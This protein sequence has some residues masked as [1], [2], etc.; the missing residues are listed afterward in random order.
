MVYSAVFFLLALSG[1]LGVLVQT[2]SEHRWAILS[3]L[4]GA[5]PDLPSARISAAA[6]QD[7]VQL[8]AP[9]CVAA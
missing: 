8:L 6:R 2:I 3:A 5:T 7:P 9:R 4:D 1:A